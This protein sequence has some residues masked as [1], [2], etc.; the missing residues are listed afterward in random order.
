VNMKTRW[1]VRLYPRAWRE[2]YEE[3]FVA[4]LEQRP[5]SLADALDVVLGALDAHLDPQV[6]DERTAPMVNRMRA[7]TIAILCAYVGFV[8]AG[9]G[10]QKV[11]E[12]PPFTNLESTHALLGISYDV[13]VDGSIVALLAM[14]AGGIPI[15]LA[16]LKRAFAE[17]RWD[18]LLL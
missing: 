3:E 5:M 15:L 18:I 2:R 1:L 12:G 9:M 17:R 10:F 14:M 13:V 7:A 11:T 6:G 8:L 16:T 4:M